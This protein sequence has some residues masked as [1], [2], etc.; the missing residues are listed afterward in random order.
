MFECTFGTRRQKHA[1]LYKLIIYQ[2]DYTLPEEIIKTGRRCPKSSE[3]R[4][5][6][7]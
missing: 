7:G 4:E 6:Y 3:I 5:K 1:R 2:S